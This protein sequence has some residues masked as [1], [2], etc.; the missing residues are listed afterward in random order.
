MKAALRV[1]EM[2]L[3]FACYSLFISINCVFL[4]AVLRLQD[5]D[6]ITDHS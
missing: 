5:A 6:D 1:L 4:K 2:S 3:Y